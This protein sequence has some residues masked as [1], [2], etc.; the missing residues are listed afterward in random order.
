MNTKKV[1]ISIISGTLILFIWNAISWMALP[2]HA[3]TLNTIPDEAISISS[4]EAGLS[5]DGV[6]HYP[7]LPK[8]NS[9]ESMEEIQQKWET[10]PR[11][12]L[13]VYKQGPSEIFDPFQ[14]LRSLLI[15]MLVAA[16]A[17][18]IVSR[19]KDHSTKA[20]LLVC[21]SVGLII[22]IASDLAQMNWYL[23]PLPYTLANMFDH[24]ISFTLLGLL[25]GYY[26][27]SQS[28]ISPDA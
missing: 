27:F 14:F 25:F 3:Q 19:T 28:Q 18:F 15:N 9:P 23:F 22:G 12:P 13:M 26:T 1:V 2:F 11:I 16:G 10:G 8:D 5:K 4:M 24:L 6:Y 20:V 7:G 21:I 17:L